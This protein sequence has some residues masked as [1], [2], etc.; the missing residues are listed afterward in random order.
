[1]V[2]TIQYKEEEKGYR[3]V[4]VS[5]SNYPRDMYSTDDENGMTSQL[6]N[7][8]QSFSFLNKV[9]KTNNFH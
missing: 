3:T 6:T 9:D 2:T 4:F 7:A 5:N 8:V 1:M